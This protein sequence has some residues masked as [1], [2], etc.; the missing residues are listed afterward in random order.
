M[1]STTRATDL[2]QTFSK[3]GKVIGAKVVTNARTPG[4]RCYGF[5]TM[6]TSEDAS[7]CISNLDR[8]ELHGRMISVERAKGDATGPPR[9]KPAASPAGDKKHDDRK[10]TDDNKDKKADSGK[11]EDDRD[12][13]KD[14]AP[15]R[16]QRQRITAP[17]PGP[18]PPTQ[19]TKPPRPGARRP[20]SRSPIPRVQGLHTNRPPPGFTDR[21]NSSVLT[22]AHIKEER[23]RQRLREKDREM[24]EEARRRRE[25]IERQKQRERFQRE[26]AQRL[27]RLREL[28]MAERSVPAPPPP[29]ASSSSSRWPHSGSGPAEL[30]PYED[31]PSRRNLSKRPS[32]H[33][34]DP[35]YE[36]R[37]SKRPSSTSAQSSSVSERRGAGGG[38]GGGYD[39][40]QT[41]PPPPRFSSGPSSK[42]TSEVRRDA[43]FSHRS[44]GGSFDRPG[45]PSGE[46]S[47]P[48]GGGSYDRSGPSSRRD[49]YFDRREA[50]GSA[51]RGGDV[52]SRDLE[53]PNR[54]KEDRYDRGPHPRD[55]FRSG[56]RAVDRPGSDRDR[57]PP[58]LDPRGGSASAGGGGSTSVRRDNSRDRYTGDA[59]GRADRH[60]NTIPSGNK[61]FT[62]GGS[63][64]LM[65]SGVGGGSSNRDPWSVS[66]ERAN[67][68]G[69]AWGRNNLDTGSTARWGGSSGLGVASRGTGGSIYTNSVPPLTAL[70][71]GNLAGTGNAG[72]GVYSGGDR[73]DAYKTLPSLRKY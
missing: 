17:S 69:G 46:R 67:D 58:S 22:F 63:Q 39:V 55:T 6:A 35:Y 62:S 32:D 26:E 14:R 70:N 13:N 11:P 49:G 53:P 15:A 7:K 71:L 12:R 47:A 27:E 8:T 23:E 20:R 61:G 28:A 10:K 36:E 73:F 37:P 48:S 51:G 64:S 45:A 1:S 2:K 3:F 29:V 68:S 43:D 5:V 25:E 30:V 18:Q 9:G 21:K 44:G 57:D 50:G 42:R 59:G 24:R 56:P 19:T 41:A 60:S 4:A 40:P 66:N 31:P 38:T 65:G 72:T 33:R 16:P 54:S 34:G 52:R